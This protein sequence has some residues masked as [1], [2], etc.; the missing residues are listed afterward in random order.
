MSLIL[1]LLG[2]L[3][4]VFGGDLLVRSASALA[5]RL[6]VSRLVIGLTVVAFGTSAPELA[7]TLASS[8]RGAPD[9]G[10]GNVL[11]SNIANVGL[12]LGLGALIVTIPSNASF[13]RR[14]VP[15]ALVAMALTYPMVLDG[16]LGRVD[17][18]LLLALLA[19]Y[20][21]FL[22]MRDSN[23]IAEEVGDPDDSPMWRR[24]GGALLGLGMLVVGADAVVQ[25]AVE[26]ATLLGVSERVI[27]LTLVAFGTSLPELAS[28]LA[29]AARRQGDMI[30][31]NIAGS[32]IFNILAVLGVSA[33]ATIIPVDAAAIVVDLAV[34]IAF[35]VVLLPIMAIRG[36]LGRVAGAV[37][38]LGYGAYVAYLFTPAG[39]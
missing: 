28:T 26:I 4:L 36:N 27:G 24:A 23:A 39:A 3:L 35:S 16:R 1:L 30:L 33:G 15:V 18:L 31:G 34:A 13:L 11:G 5:V 2:L 17:G 14:D 25:G 37:L 6:G 8:L 22:M 21:A 10:V 29:A 7:A 38:V 19:G 9:V 12:I 20:L 32:N